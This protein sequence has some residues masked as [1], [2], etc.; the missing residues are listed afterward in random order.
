V[1]VHAWQRHV[2]TAKDLLRPAWATPAQRDAAHDRLRGWVPDV[3][4]E[5]GADLHPTCGGPLDAL[6]RFGDAADLMV[7][8]RAARSG[9]GSALYDSVGN[10]LAGPAPCPIVFI[11][12]RPPPV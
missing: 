10:D 12:S 5:I 6:L 3:I 7:L 2:E 11:P 8:G 1:V 9:W 4:G